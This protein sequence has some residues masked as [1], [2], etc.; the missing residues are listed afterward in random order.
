MKLN[1]KIIFY[2]IIF[3]CFITLTIMFG[4]AAKSTFLAQNSFMSAYYSFYLI[5]L[6]LVSILFIY[7]FIANLF[8]LNKPLIDKIK[9]KYA[10]KKASRAEKSK[11]AKQARIEKLETE[12]EKLKND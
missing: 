2:F 4:L 6:I 8:S 3:L 11:A 9:T 1:F 7:K 12:L 10:E 5:C